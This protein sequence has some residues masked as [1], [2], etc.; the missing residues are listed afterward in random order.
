MSHGYNHNKPLALRQH[1]RHWICA[2]LDT[3]KSQRKESTT[4][5]LYLM[6]SLID[7]TTSSSETKAAVTYMASSAI[8]HAFSPI[9]RRMKPFSPQSDAQLFLTF[10]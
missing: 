2:S 4:E 3:A 10:Q 7:H 8:P 5:A 9:G 6:M 1:L